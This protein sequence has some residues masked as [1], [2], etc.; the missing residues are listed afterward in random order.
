[1]M[2]KAGWKDCLQTTSV[3]LMAF[4]RPNWLL[5]PSTNQSR[6]CQVSLGEAVSASI[7]FSASAVGSAECLVDS[8]AEDKKSWL[9]IQC[10]RPSVGQG[11]PVLSGVKGD[12]SGWK[13]KVLRA[14]HAQTQS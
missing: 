6:S 13:L 11:R 10:P 4:W 8:S 3:S 7:V 2:A 14:L 9:P 1:M 12:Q 5:L